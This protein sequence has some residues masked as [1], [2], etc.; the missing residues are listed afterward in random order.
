MKQREKKWLK[1]LV[2]LLLV[3]V[4]ADVMTRLLL[5]PEEKTPSRCLAIPTKFIL[6]YPEC[7]QRLIEVANLTNV[8]VV[9]PGTLEERRYNQSKFYNMSR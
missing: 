6:E 5:L 8:R 1:V 7:S 4:I 2:I 9:P 3:A